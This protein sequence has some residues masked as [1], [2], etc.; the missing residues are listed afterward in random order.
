[1]T[2]LFDFLTASVKLN[3]P[4]LE[5]LSKTINNK[6]MWI[7]IIALG[8]FLLVIFFI[9]TYKVVDPNDAHVVVIMGRG[10]KIYSPKT[11]EGIRT[12]TAYFYIPL[13]MKRFILPLTNVKMDIPDI[14]LNDIEVAPFIC[15]VITWLHIDDPITAA[16]RLNLTEPFISLKEDLV[17]IV[18]AVARAVAMKQEVLEIMRDRATFSQAVSAEVGDVLND[19][20]VKLINLEVND[21]RDDAEKQSSVISDYE[22][23]RKADI[24]SK[25]RKEVATKDREA[26]EIEQNN[27]EK[28]AIATA[29][30]EENL[31]KRQ[32]EKDKQI[33]IEAQNKDL[34]IARQEESANEQKVSALRKLEVGKATVTKEATIEKAIGEAE[35]IRVTGDKEADVIK[36]TGEAEG[37]AIEAKGRAQALA[38]DKMA[39]AMQ[40]FN[41]AATNIEKIRAWI[42]VEKA[43]YEALGMALAEADLKLVNSGDKGS[44]FGFPITAQ[45]GADLAQMVEAMGGIDKVKDAAKK[46]VSEVK[47]VI[48]G[49]E[50]DREK[51]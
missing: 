23:I 13:L 6:Y 33:G 18:Q 37:A 26:V 5:F 10:R 22:S 45:M 20:G 21:I 43:K 9:L 14:H 34:A 49:E 1:L 17:N 11:K 4:L 50:T 48:K 46:V 36:L 35:A 47:D 8:G 44:I 24:N 30:A 27:R 31:T 42:E 19:W 51:E 40:K 7:G 2:N 3:S 15:D 38:K 32:I 28:A 25:A 12:R 41:D 39:E 16:E 29:I